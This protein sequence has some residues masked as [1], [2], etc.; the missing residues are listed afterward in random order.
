L[1]LQK[2]DFDKIKADGNLIIE[3][4][5]YS[6]TILGATSDGVSLKLGE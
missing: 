5:P 6:G 2:E 1:Q 4:A 3:V